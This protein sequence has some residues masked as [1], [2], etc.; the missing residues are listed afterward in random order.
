MPCPRSLDLE[1]ADFG[2]ETDSS[3]LLRTTHAMQW[4]YSWPSECEIEKVAR[5]KGDGR[6]AMD[7]LKSESSPALSV[8]SCLQTIRSLALAYLSIPIRSMLTLR[9]SR[10]S[11]ND[12]EV[13]IILRSNAL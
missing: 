8:L 12:L 4:V 11:F 10:D 2:V 1:M 6:L 7:R 3:Y 13:R 5:R 9:R